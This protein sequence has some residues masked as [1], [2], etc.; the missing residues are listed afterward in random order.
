MPFPAGENPWSLRTDETWRRTSWWGTCMT[1]DLSKSSNSRNRLK[2]T[3]NIDDRWTYVKILKQCP[4]KICELFSFLFD[5]GTTVQ[6]PD[7]IWTYVH[8]HIVSINQYFRSINSILKSQLTKWEYL[9]W[10]IEAPSIEKYISRLEKTM[11]PSYILYNNINPNAIYSS[12]TL[13]T[14]PMMLK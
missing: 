4:S 2:T 12:Y 5:R 6:T 13:K 10:T 3:I 9:V 14:L 7:V 11:F 8:Y 1:F